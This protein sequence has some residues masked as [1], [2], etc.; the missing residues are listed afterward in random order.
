MVTVKVVVEQILKQSGKCPCI[1]TSTVW[2]QKF[3]WVLAI[4]ILY[5]YVYIVVTG[6]HR[7]YNYAFRFANLFWH[8]Y[9]E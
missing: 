5:M 7:S 6:T 4:I 1:D 8:E 2:L 9:Q 3:A